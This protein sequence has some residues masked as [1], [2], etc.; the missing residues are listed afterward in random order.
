MR[1]KEKLPSNK[2]K[3]FS[4]EEPEPAQQRNANSQY[5]PKAKPP[6]P[7][8]DKHDRTTQP[9]VLPVRLLSQTLLLTKTAVP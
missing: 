1:N 8:A 2:A 9:T 7:L 3:I 6:L 4:K 5:Q